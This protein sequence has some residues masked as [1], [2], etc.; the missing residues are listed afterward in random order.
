V[1]INNDF[2]DY[3]DEV[4]QKPIIEN[5]FQ[6]KPPQLWKKQT[7]V[8]TEDVDS[9][10]TKRKSASKTNIIKSQNQNQN[11]NKEQKK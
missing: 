6:L 9:L 10:R 4:E 1:E 11:Q 8:S 2:E 5:N 3:E 7:N